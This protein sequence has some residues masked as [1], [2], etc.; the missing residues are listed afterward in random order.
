[1]ASSPSD[2]GKVKTRRAESVPSWGVRLQ[3]KTLQ[4]RDRFRLRRLMARHRGLEIHPSASSNLAAARYDL[5]LS[6]INDDPDFPDDSVKTS[7]WNILVG[8]SF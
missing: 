5:G 6:N 3:L 2:S 1:M 7:A 4:A 8:V